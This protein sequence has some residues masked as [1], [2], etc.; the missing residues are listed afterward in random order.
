M[1]S[2]TR[3]NDKHQAAKDN[4]VKQGFSVDTCQPIDKLIFLRGGPAARRFLYRPAHPAFRRTGIHPDE[5]RRLWR[6]RI[7]TG[8]CH[9]WSIPS[10]SHVTFPCDRQLDYRT[11]AW[12]LQYCNAL[13]G[14]CS[15]FPRQVRL[16][17][18]KTSVQSRCG[19]CENR[20]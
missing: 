12:P 3:Y 17:I 14:S 7:G 13:H 9:S 5:M 1:T 16:G 4:K 6:T 20:Q 11:L 2:R 19:T 8:S 10:K 18:L 15:V